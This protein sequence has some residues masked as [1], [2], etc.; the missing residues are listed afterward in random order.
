MKKKLSNKE[1]DI[2][3]KIT[4]IEEIVEPKILNRDIRMKSK[5]IS[6]LK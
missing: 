4:K 1:I 5:N 3:D 2:M 6:S